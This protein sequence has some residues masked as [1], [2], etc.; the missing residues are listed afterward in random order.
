MKKMKLFEISYRQQPNP[1][2]ILKA[3]RYGESRG[4]VAQAWKQLNKKF[5]ITILGIKQLS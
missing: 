5:P 2:K 1:I 3:V 4:H